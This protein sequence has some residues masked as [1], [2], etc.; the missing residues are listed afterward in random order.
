MHCYTPRTHPGRHIHTV[1]TPVHTQGGIYQG[2]YLSIRLSGRRIYQAYT[3][4]LGSGRL[5]PGYTSLSGSREAYTRVNTFKTGS[6]EPYFP[7]HCWPGIRSQEA[8]LPVIA[9][10]DRDILDS[11]TL[12]SPVLTGFTLLVRN[13]GIRRPWVGVPRRL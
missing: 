2:V 4:L 3:S 6:R 7:F 12:Y 10:Q 9:S 1:Y 8:S 5:I 11:F 13:G